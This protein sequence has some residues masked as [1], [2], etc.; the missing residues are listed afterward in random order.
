MTRCP[1]CAEEVQDAA[2]KC[3]HCGSMLDGSQNSGPEMPGKR[4]LFRSRRER[5]FSGVC[6]GLAAYAGMDAALMRLLV[7]LGIFA[8]GIV[9]GIIAYIV[10]AVIIPEENA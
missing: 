9:P 6:G 7:A 1:Y 8:T 4:R 3:K 2:V 5:M 10:A